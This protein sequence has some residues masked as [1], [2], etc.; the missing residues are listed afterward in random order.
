M[1]TSHRIRLLIL[2]IAALLPRGAA[3]QQ[4]DW[5][6][7]SVVLFVA[8]WCAPCHGEVERVPALVA[9][10][11]PWRVL[12]ASGDRTPRPRLLERVPAANR[13][14]PDPVTAVRVRR[15]LLSRTAGLPYAAVLDRDGHLCAE[16][17]RPLNSA[18]LR[19][20]LAQCD[21]RPPAAP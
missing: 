15:E 5:P 20:L 10:A 19:A 7:A 6:S 4:V 17:A 1:W 14:H 18:R 13:W 8:D 16:S 3:A 21:G 2:T 12:V 9:A 11:Q